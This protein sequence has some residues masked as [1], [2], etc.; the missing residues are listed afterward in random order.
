VDPKA[1]NAATTMSPPAKLLR[2]CLVPNLQ[3]LSFTNNYANQPLWT[4]MTITVTINNAQSNTACAAGIGVYRR[5]IHMD[6]EGHW[7]YSRIVTDNSITQALV[8]KQS[9]SG[10]SYRLVLD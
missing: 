6:L 1:G 7:R 10:H 3:A 8:S 5:R 4:M 2:K 9:L